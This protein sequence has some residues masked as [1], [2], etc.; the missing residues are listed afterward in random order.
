M[1]NLS[2]HPLLKKTNPIKKRGYLARFFLAQQ[3][4]R[5]LNGSML[6]GITGSVGKTTTAIACKSVLSQRYPTISTTDTIPT[7]PNLDP[8][9]NLPMTI[10]R[11][12]PNI[13]KVILE[14]GIEYPG[15]MDLYLSL[16]K[17][18]TAIVT[19][20]FFAHSEF[21]GDVDEIAK[22]KGK[23]VRQLPK[24]GVAILNWDDPYVRKLAQETEAEVIFYGT[25][26]KNCHVWAGNIKVENFTTVFELN[27]GVERVLVR[28]NLLGVHQV[29]PLLAAA[30]LGINLG[31]PLT[32][33]KKAL[34]KVEGLDHRMQAAAGPNGSILID[35]TYNSSPAALEEALETI[36]KIPARRR[37]V[38]LGEM[39]ELGEYSEKLHRSVGRKIYKDKLDL[40]IT[41]GG[42]ARFIAEELL[43]LGFIPERLHSGLQNAQIASTL[44]KVIGRGDVVLIKASQAVRFKEIVQ[45]LKKK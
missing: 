35:D 5:L 9:F 18:K 10:L 29:Y 28:S 14:M 33:V 12:R 30:A 8:I 42:N 32:L 24:D 15:E 36:N 3:Y 4:A 2:H 25:D 34:E 23:L 45:R 20:I 31:I 43:S 7:L 22:E 11:V 27:Y 17:P 38:V 6:V 39:R 13:K 19:R 16:V 21:L 40:V 26:Q 44:L 41:S 37:I 1:I